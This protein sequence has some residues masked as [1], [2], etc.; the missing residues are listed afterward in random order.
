M[1]MNFSWINFVCMIGQKQREE[2]QDN[3][4]IGNDF[5]ILGTGF[6]VFYKRPYLVTARHLIQKEGHFINNICCIFDYFTK[7][8]FEQKKEIIYI[9]NT[10]WKFHRSDEWLY[11]QGND[12]LIDIAVTPVNV[13]EEMSKSAIHWGRNK[14]NISSIP[15]RDIMIGNEVRVLGYPLQF[16]SENDFTPTIRRGIV[17]R[18]IENTTIFKEKKFIKKSFLIDSFIEDGNSG[19]PIIQL[20]NFVHSKVFGSYTFDKEGLIG[21]AT[22][23]YDS[24]RVHSGL[25]IC[26]SSDY[27]KEILL[28]F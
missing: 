1:S 5:T 6:L 13:S 27:I 8:K 20:E 9:D 24:I 28:E 15:F 26:K 7:K 3:F 14:F 18:I 25:G 17:A 22:G 10:Q 11:E 23:H 16:V 2:I 4:V 12:Y 21:I 19:S